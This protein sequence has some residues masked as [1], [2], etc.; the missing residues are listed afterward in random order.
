VSADL[1]SLV[2]AEGTVLAAFEESCR[3]HPERPAVSFLGLRIP[4]RELCDQAL[5][6]AA[7]CAALGVSEGDR[8]LLYLP[9]CPQWLVAYLGAQALGAVPVPVSPLYT[10]RELAFLL[11]SSGAGAVVCAD[12]NFGYVRQAA[13]R[14]P[15]IKVI[16]TGLVDLLPAWKRAFGRLFDR[17]PTGAVDRG[18]DVY[19]LRAL[20]RSHRPV[21]PRRAA[22]PQRD[23]AHLLYT[24]GTTGF[25]KGVPHTHQE[26]LSGIVGLRE[27]YRGALAAGG[28]RLLVPLPLFH[29]FTQDMVLALG[30]HLGNTLALLPR[31][32]PDAVL[33]AVGEERATLLIGVPS[34]YRRLLDCPRQAHYGLGT[35][36]ACWSAGD[37]LPGETA[38]A[39]KRRT[40]LPIHQVY[41][42]TETVCVAATPLG[43]DPAPGTVGRVIGTRRVRIVD[44]ESLEEVPPGAA[45][46]L[47]VG[48]ESAEG[49][50]AYW[51]NAAET[52]AAYV[53]AEGTR[54]CR[55]GD[56]VR[57][58]PQGDLEFLD[59]R[60][61]LIKHK[62]FRVSAARVESV[63]QDHPAV[64]AAAVVG[65]PNAEAGENVKAFVILDR[66]A[67]GVGAFDLVR[68]CRERLLPYEV[69]DHIE[70]RD[71]LPRSK[72]GKV[73]RR[74]LR[75][76]ERRKGRGGVR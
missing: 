9:N 72:V 25:P 75:E 69:P 36:R 14:G 4:Y 76:E 8:V 11:R 37:V 32:L 40:G 67:R 28:E 51:E 64:L 43:A 45:G 54:W 15:G 42:S 46:E 12:T 50:A 68:H 35:L 52:E 38:E 39:W 7:A 71:M 26:L 19:A 29:M 44:P 60:A 70:F 16:V 30:L 6:F 23:L 58:T 24:G 5:R 31:P 55:T 61:D 33:A 18:R 22:H 27:L 73:L 17:V 47:L 2:D 21:P 57:R 74:E 13:D 3:R 34:L 59:R 49:T 10:P 41:G 53:S 20:L 56:V 65:T 48:S 63:L 62:G 1:R 66:D